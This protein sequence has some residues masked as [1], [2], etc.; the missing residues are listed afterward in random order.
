[1]AWLLGTIERR[2]GLSLIGFVEDGASGDRSLKGHPI[3]SWESFA[4]SHPDALVTV[5]VADPQLRRNLAAKCEAARYSFATLVFRNVE[6]S[7]WV[8]LGCGVTICSSC[9]LTVDVVL[10]RQVH[11]NKDCTI[12]H[13]VRIGEF[14]TVSPGVHISGNVRIGRGVFIGAGTT[15]VNGTPETPLVIGDGAV[16]AA[17]ACVTHST[18]ADALYAG[19]PATLKK[20]YRA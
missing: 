3:L 6:M 19:V 20:R 1:V 5:A 14:S 2:D 15:I 18:E 8:E 4:R 7:P 9:I 12:G 17:G 13:D 11:L 16:I 10:E